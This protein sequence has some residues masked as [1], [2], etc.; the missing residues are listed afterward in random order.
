MLMRF[1][2]FA[3]LGL[4]VAAG[5]V[6]AH[7]TVSPA[8]RLVHE[9]MLVLDTHLDT[10]VLFERPGWDFTRWHEYAWD[11]SQLDIPRMEAGGLDGGFF[12]IYTPQG[13][14]DEAAMIKAR[15]D[16]LMRATAIQRVVAANPDKLAFATTA[17]DAE[18]IHREGKRI[19]FQ[20]I[21]NSYPLG[22]DVSLL[23]LYYR[24]GVRM[25]GPVHSKNNQFA[26]STTDTP[27]WNG[28]S[29]L[30]RQWVAEMN[31][32][33]MIV[34]GSH[35]S[36][37]VFDQLLALSK[38]PMILSHSGPRA[39][40]NHPRN[41]DDERMRRL[42]K[43]G[44][45]M[46]VNSVFLVKHDTSEERDAIDARQQKWESLNASERRK[47][48]ADKAALDARQPYTN[49]TFEMF[50]KSLLHSIGVMGVD[51]VGIGADWDGGG[52][53]IGMEDIASL[54]KVTARLRKEGFS[55]SDIA[56]IMGGNLLR[57]MRAV[58]KQ[59]GR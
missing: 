25:A 33:G 48:V 20:S 52:G 29:P 5:P 42:A 37:A 56:K 44:G 59:A 18:R 6:A 22:D 35:S 36:D 57:V 34:D 14:L 12:V 15:D 17:D 4:A 16:A 32:L 45:V 41:I 43:A 19:V 24:L 13:G 27:R 26:D 51:H 58:E 40:F 11:V 38:A 2:A 55:E 30:G 31:R 46:F 54:P 9:Q 28:L 8:D 3:A 7:D 50:I 23:G 47:L 21:E 39:I 53:V 10:P 1:A 49:A